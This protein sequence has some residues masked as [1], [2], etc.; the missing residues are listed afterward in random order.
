MVM[1]RQR[2]GRVHQY[3]IDQR[4]PSRLTGHRAY[5][6]GPPLCLLDQ[7]LHAVGRPHPLAIRLWELEAREAL[8]HA[9]F[10]AYDRILIAIAVT[11]QDLFETE[12]ATLL[13][14][15]GERIAVFVDDWN[16]YHRRSGEVHCGTNVIRLSPN[17]A[18]DHWWEYEP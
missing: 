9:L 15:P 11:R 3:R 12:I 2:F 6:V 10:R 8:L 1:P 5:R 4:E 16:V 13:N 7:P 14:A 17:E 18:F